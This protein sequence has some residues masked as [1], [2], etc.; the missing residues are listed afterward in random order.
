MKVGA[1]DKKK[2][3][4]MAALLALALLLIVRTL[5]F[6]NGAP[7]ASANAATSPIAAV[8]AS[9][10]PNLTLDPTLRTD[11]LKNSEGAEYRGSGRNIFEEQAAP[12]PQPTKTVVVTPSPTPPPPGPPPPPPIPL[13]FFGFANNPGEPKSIFLAQGEDIFIGHEGEIVNR[14]YKIVH[15]GSNAVEIEDVMNSNRQS[16]PL[17]QG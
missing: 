2:L 14:R 12:L 10:G 8:R 9:K 11:L 15:I 6:S 5:F 16:I 13:K 4:A 7:A 17:T 3:Y 1:E